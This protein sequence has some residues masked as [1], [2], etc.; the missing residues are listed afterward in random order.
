M[1]IRSLNIDQFRAVEL[2]DDLSKSIELIEKKRWVITRSELRNFKLLMQLHH[3]SFKL[4]LCA[5]YPCL[6]EI[7]V[8]RL[9]HLVL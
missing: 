2:F 1:L 4:L 5:G 7:H 8:V 9:P 3:V 6:H